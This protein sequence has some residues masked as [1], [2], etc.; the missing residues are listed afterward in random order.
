M[1]K[2]ATNNYI[3][4]I[5]DVYSGY[6]DSKQCPTKN[7]IMSHGGNA[8][9]IKNSGNYEN[10]QCV[11]ES[12]ITYGSKN[13]KVFLIITS[14]DNRDFNSFNIKRGDS[15]I[16]SL[17]AF[18]VDSKSSSFGGKKYTNK[19]I[20]VVKHTGK[21]ANFTAVT[22]SNNKT[23]QFYFGKF[24]GTCEAVY[25]KLDT[26][27]NINNIGDLSKYFTN[28]LGS[29]DNQKYGTFDSGIKWNQWLKENKQ[30]VLYLD[31]RG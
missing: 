9:F 31:F 1:G 4:G 10:D 6:A 22:S 7:Q 20:D 15:N 17:G 14:G 8:I 12:D 28:S 5:L 18:N 30:I 25:C 3:K 21:T 26:E 23:V 24:S 19:P 27:D 13:C 11:K 29:L 16:K 2:I